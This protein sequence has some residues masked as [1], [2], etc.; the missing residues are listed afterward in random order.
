MCIPLKISTQGKNLPHPYTFLPLNLGKIGIGARFHQL[1]A[2]CKL[3]KAR[4][5]S[6]NFP[7]CPQ[8]QKD[9]AF[10]NVCFNKIEPMLPSTIL[11]VLFFHFLI[12]YYMLILLFYVFKCEWWF[13]VNLRISVADNQNTDRI[14]SR[15]HLRHSH[16]PV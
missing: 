8:L 11:N 13:P 5:Y 7:K 9:P 2:S 6:N 1:R 15:F 12:I 3:Q 16:A 10:W 14:P 4:Q